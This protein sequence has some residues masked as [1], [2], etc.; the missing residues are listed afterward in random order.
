M[1]AT[2]NTATPPRTVVFK[3]WTFF[4][5][6]AGY[7][8][9][10]ARNRKGPPNLHRA[11]W[12]DA[13]GPVPDGCDI[14]HRDGNPLNNFL[15]NLECIAAADHNRM[16]YLERIA[17]GS[18]DADA[19]RARGLEEAKKWHASPKGRERH[20]QD[21]LKRW[22]RPPIPL[23]CERCDA[24]Y[25]APFKGRHRFCSPA[26]YRAADNERRR[27]QYAALRQ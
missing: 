7:Y 5:V 3:E 14:H 22:A 21:A 23:R 25:E 2:V 15:D 13:Y 24:S 19:L 18:L 16:H 27:A 4:L 9:R 20:R 17:D 26:C 8:C 10:G 11:I 6:P 12:E 1:V